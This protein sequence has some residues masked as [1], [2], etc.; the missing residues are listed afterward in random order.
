MRS[1]GA[2]QGPSLPLVLSG[3]GQQA[4]LVT[5]SRPCQSAAHRQV[6]RERRLHVFMEAS[7]AKAAPGARQN[8]RGVHR[9]VMLHVE[10]YSPPGP[11]CVSAQRYGILAEYPC[12]AQAVRD[13]VNA[14]TCIG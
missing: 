6:N 5:T 7:M 3:P 10:L 8:C 12:A 2:A 9:M 11:A 1:T 14:R 13:L 4:P